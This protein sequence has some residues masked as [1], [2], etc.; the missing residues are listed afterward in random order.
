V[1][2]YVVASAAWSVAGFIAGVFVGRIERD[3]QKIKD[4]LEHQMEG[5]HDDHA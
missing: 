1:W 3:V 4:T 5:D 2:E